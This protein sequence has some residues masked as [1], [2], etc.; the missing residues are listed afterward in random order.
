MGSRSSGGTSQSGSFWPRTIIESG[1]RL[2]SGQVSEKAARLVL[3]A[4]DMD[5]LA[6]DLGGELIGA[7]NDEERFARRC[8]LDAAFFLLYGLSP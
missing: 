8:E 4:D 1:P 3:T 5:G 2:G 7:W 6:G